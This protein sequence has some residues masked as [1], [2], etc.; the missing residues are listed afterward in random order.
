M[1]DIGLNQNLSV[2]PREFHLQTA[3]ILDEGIIRTE[4]FQK[5]RLL[6]VENHRYE[7]RDGKE[8]RGAEAR[9]RRI[10]DQFHQAIIEEIDSLFEISDRVFD[11]NQPA[12]HEKIGLVFLY[13][14]IFDK[15]ELHFKRSIE[16]QPDRKSSYVYLGRCYYL[17]K[18]YQQAIEILSNLPDNQTNYPDVHNLMGLI[19][20][21][22]RNFR[23]AFDYFKLA[24]NQNSSYIEAFFNLAEALMQRTITL[25]QSQ[26]REAE[27]K[28]STDF[29]K[30]MLK[31]IHTHGN[32]EDRQ[33][34][35]MI[36]KA[37]LQNDMHK[38]LSLIHE[39]REKN[40]VR[41]VPPEVVGYQFYLRLF[42]SEEELSSEA[43]EGYE[44]KIASALEY[45]PSYADLWHYLALI[46]LMQCRHYFLAG[47]DNFRDATRI[48]PNF[49][50]AVKNL[51]LVE[52][53]GREFLS[54]I[55]T[56]V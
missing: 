29:I 24:L 27:I 4:V 25:L 22:K 7:R 39:H 11:E 2:G 10:V 48:N 50:K 52:N 12:P 45:N 54:L 30:I 36:S 51:R 8:E 5:G 16:L 33:Q 9:L 46:H 34:S 35:S 15:A 18:R 47:L 53:D 49:E 32:A 17:Q 6:F 14:H 28:K 23:K 56:I 37:L 38:A 20:T 42:Y 55:K 41:R 43:L 19:M 40:Y 21:E 44:E 13:M 3:T 26:E 1:A 31:K